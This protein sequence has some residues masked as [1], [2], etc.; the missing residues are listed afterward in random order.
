M[1]QISIY[2]ILI[3]S[4]MACVKNTPLVFDPQPKDKIKKDSIKLSPNG[5]GSLLLDLDND[6]IND[7]GIYCSAS[8]SGM[9]AVN[10]KSLDS[11]W[12]LHSKAKVFCQNKPFSYSKDTLKLSDTTFSIVG[13]T[14]VNGG[15]NIIWKKAKDVVLQMDSLSMYQPLPLGSFLDGNFLIHHRVYNAN[16]CGLGWRVDGKWYTV[17][18]TM[19]IEN[20]KGDW[21]LFEINKQLYAI[22]FFN[23]MPYKLIYSGY[24]IK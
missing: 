9:C 4:A 5:A 23:I 18:E 15:K 24:K 1:K 13:G 17:N 14:N 22:K 2:L 8:R 16:N 10:Q 7:I 3:V 6:D 11:V 20:R 21:I 12:T 19:L